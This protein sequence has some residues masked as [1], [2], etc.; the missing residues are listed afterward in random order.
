MLILLASTFGPVET[1]MLTPSGNACL[2]GITSARFA[3][4]RSVGAEWN[5]YG[6]ATEHY[7]FTSTPFMAALMPES[8]QIEPLPVLPLLE[9]LL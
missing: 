4:A 8:M 2:T 3:T 1:M 9:P 6:G 5:G 7:K